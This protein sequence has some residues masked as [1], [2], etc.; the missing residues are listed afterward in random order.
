MC[1]T[2]EYDN[3]KVN[4]LLSCDVIHLSGGDPIFLLKNINK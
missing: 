1:Q 4:D 2:E 3:S